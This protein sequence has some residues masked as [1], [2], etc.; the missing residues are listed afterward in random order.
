[1]KHQFALL[2][3]IALGTAMMTSVRSYG[4]VPPP[5][6]GHDEECEDNLIFS[7]WDDVLFVNNGSQRFTAYQWYCADTLV[8]GAT[9]QYIHKAGMA[10][11]GAM[12]YAVATEVNGHKVTC[13]PKLF[14]DFPASQP[15]NPAEQV[16]KVAL[17]NNTGRK[18]G[19]WDAKPN[20][21]TL[22]LSRGCYIWYFTNQED[23][24][25]SEKMLIP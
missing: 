16:R 23:N 2:L 25:W 6:P 12:Y 22:G 1:M 9:D 7:K 4:E 8:P 10:T 17:Y 13:C 19:E 5:P 3:C 14:V 20:I 18:M 11:D 15:L 21:N 24:S